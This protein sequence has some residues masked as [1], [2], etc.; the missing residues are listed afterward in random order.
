GYQTIFLRRGFAVYILDQPRRGRAGRSTEGVTITPAPNEQ[1][2]FQIFRLGIWPNFFPGVQFPSDPGSLDQ[3]F[4][5]QTPDMG[6]LGVARRGLLTDAVAALFDKIGPAVLLTH[7]ASGRLGWLTAIKSEN[8]KAIVCYETG[9]FV[10]PEGEVPP[11][12]VT[13]RGT[14]EG[15]PV[16]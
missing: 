4:R 16:P 10:F 5:Q 11:P 12:I 8:V 1:E 3:F 14:T 7:S 9:A 13:P 15:Q 6:P 2:A